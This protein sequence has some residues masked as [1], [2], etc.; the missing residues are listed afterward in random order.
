MFGLRSKEIPENS[1]VAPISGRLIPI[2]EVKDE[3]FASKVLGEGIAII[4]SDDV[5]VAPC[6]G[7]LT[8]L[9]PTLHAF[10]MKTAD[11]LDILIH[12]GINTVALKGEGFKAFA[13]QGDIVEIG[14]KIIYFDSY[15][16]KNESIDT[17]VMMIFP[18][19]KFKLNIQ[20]QGYVKKR[21]DIVVSYEQQ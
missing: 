1:L 17:T 11:G 5:V 19:C 13:A 8:M 21:K 16:M 10:G 14:Q 18:Q 20:K 6:S 4:P 9:F 3:A 7:T 12:I 2:E 15:W